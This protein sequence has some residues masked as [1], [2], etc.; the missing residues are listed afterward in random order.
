MTP[1]LLSS[2]DAQ[3]S[4]SEK[5][6]NSAHLD[7]RAPELGGPVLLSYLVLP[8][9]LQAPNSAEAISGAATEA[10]GARTEMVIYRKSGNTA[11]L[12]RFRGPCRAIKRLIYFHQ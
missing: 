1:D 7:L 11:R 5:M 9:R 12:Q 6:L 10:L 4:N 8:G 2:S 3:G